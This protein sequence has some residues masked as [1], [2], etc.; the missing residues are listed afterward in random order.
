MKLMKWED[1][2]VTL[3]IYLFN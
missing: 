2:E 3:F 1:F